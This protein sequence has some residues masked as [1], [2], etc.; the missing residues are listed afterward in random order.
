MGSDFDFSGML[1]FVTTSNIPVTVDRV[2]PLA[3]GLTALEYLGSAQHTGKV[4]IR[5]A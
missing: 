1:S 4:I 3:E 2:F 5:C